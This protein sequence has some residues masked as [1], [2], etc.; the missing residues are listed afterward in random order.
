MKDIK[1]NPVNSE[2]PWMLYEKEGT[3]HISLSIKKRALK[4]R[5]M[6]ARYDLLNLMGQID[7]MVAN[8]PPGRK[9]QQ[10]LSDIETRKRSKRSK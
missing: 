2:I 1:S 5:W 9:S 7:D 3:I 8:M 10:R 4:Q 6:R